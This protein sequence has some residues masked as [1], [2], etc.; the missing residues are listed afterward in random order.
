[1]IL[2]TISKIAAAIVVTGLLLTGLSA[3]ANQASG[4]GQTSASAARTE[5]S[6]AT[7]SPKVIG[8]APPKSEAEIIAEKFLKAGSELFDAKDATA[9]AATYT[10]DSEIVFVDKKDGEIRYEVKQGRAD[11]E[12]FYR[13]FFQNAGAV[14]SENFVEFAR[15]ISPDLLVVHGRFRP[16]VDKTEWP[17]VQMRV[18]QGER[19]L[20]SKLWLFL[21]PGT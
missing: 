4:P 1:M 17:F 2:K 13:D 6:G 7:G 16:D 8:G 9:L 10:E 12:K 5:P 14:D 19:W 3:V 18:K 21:K 15:L 20:L 11:I